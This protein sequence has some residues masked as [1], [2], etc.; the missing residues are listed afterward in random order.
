MGWGD[1]N[2]DVFFVGQSCHEFGVYSGLPF[3][4]GSGLMIDAALRLSGLNR[5]DCF[6]SNV[7]HCH[8]ERNRMS[9][10]E[11]KESCLPYL[12]E[13]LD[14]VQPRVVVALGKDAEQGVKRYMD[15]R[16]HTWKYLHYSHPASLLYT[17]PESRPNY[18]IKLSLDLDKARGK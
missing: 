11:E 2:A 12:F 7:V 5:K 1:L 15:E 3:I 9:T 6:I 4:L 17:S 16:E 18:V 8:P 14:I 13:E 10:E